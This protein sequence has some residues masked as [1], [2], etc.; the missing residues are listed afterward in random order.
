MQIE[1]RRPAPAARGR[2]AASGRSAGR[3][4][5]LRRRS[6]RS[7]A[8]RSR[9]ACGQQLRRAAN[10]R[11]RVLD[12]MGQ[13]GRAAQRRRAARRRP[14]ALAWPVSDKR[15]HAPARMS[16]AMSDIVRLTCSSCS[17]TRMSTPRAVNCASV[18]R[19]RSTSARAPNSTMSSKRL[20]D[21]SP[22]A[23][24]PSRSLGGGIGRP[25]HQV[26]RRAAAARRS[27]RRSALRRRGAP[28]ERPR[29][30]GPAPQE[31]LVETLDF[32]EHLRRDRR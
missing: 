30:R 2:G 25:D 31:R 23:D 27:G 4:G 29:S 5:R 17:P 32:A 6:G 16:I 24:M 11:E 13:D 28:L 10:G 26:A 12:F 15:Q 21:H 3:C 7:G 9:P 18:S 1:R 22:R 20:P 19:S 8:S 14:I